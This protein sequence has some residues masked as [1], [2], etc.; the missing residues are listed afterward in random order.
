MH[1]DCNT[2]ATMVVYSC[3][4][5]PCQAPLIP[6]SLLL[7]SLIPVV[8]ATASTPPAP[9]QASPKAGWVLV[10]SLG[11]MVGAVKEEEGQKRP[12]AGAGCR[13]AKGT[14]QEAMPCQG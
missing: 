6:S 4:R 9:P 12:G 2:P 10:G 3:M 11:M 14:V 5:A 7:T 13:C 8:R 1:L